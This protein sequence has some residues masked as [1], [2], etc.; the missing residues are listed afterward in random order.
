MIKSNEYTDVTLVCD[1]NSQFKANKMVL[2]DPS[3]VLK[4]IIN[5]QQVSKQLNKFL[6]I[7]RWWE[8]KYNK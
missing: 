2:N 3:S 7:K 6:M 1:D 4:S 5:D 8:M